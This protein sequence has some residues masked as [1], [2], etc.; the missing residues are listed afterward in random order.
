MWNLRLL[1]EQGLV[2]LE[3]VYSQVTYL[4]QYAIAI[5]LKSPTQ[6]HSYSMSL[7]ILSLDIGRLINIHIILMYN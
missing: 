7:V 1:S 6:Y 2:S 3:F 4:T 5:A